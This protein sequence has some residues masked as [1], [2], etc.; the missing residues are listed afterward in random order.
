MNKLTQEAQAFARASAFEWP[1]IYTPFK[2]AADY[3]STLDGITKEA[4]ARLI[5]T[6]GNV[7][8]EYQAFVTRWEN[9]GGK[10]WEQGA[11]AA[12]RSQK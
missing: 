4:L 1:F 2:E 3:G 11:T 9:E 12:Y 7:Q 10:A 6:T 8:A 5:V